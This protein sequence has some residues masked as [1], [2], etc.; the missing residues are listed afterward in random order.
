MCIDIDT[1]IGMYVYACVPSICVYVCMCTY[2]ICVCQSE[3]KIMVGPHTFFQPKHRID[4]S[5]M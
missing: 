4:Q 2:Y 5:S 3:Y 1:L